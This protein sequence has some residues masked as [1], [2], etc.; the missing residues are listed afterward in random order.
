MKI[1]KQTLTHISAG[2]LLVLLLAAPIAA[3][4]QNNRG[5]S[6]SQVE[7]GMQGSE[8]RTDDD[9]VTSIMKWVSSLTP[10]QGGMLLVVLG[11]L[12]GGA[13]GASGGGGS[14]A[15]NTTGTKTKP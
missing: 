5:A 9:P 13:R 12:F 11:L 14:A 1:L 8:G 15:G 7:S 10:M 3:Q 4:E 6:T 2:A